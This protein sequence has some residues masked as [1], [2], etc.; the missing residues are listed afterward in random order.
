[1]DNGKRFEMVAAEVV[2]VMV[3]VYDIV[4]NCY[5]FDCTEQSW[6]YCGYSIALAIFDGGMLY[7]QYQTAHVNT[8]RG[9]NSI[10]KAFDKQA[11]DR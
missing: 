10:G 11:K 2:G 8:K 4:T 3:H 1:M 5:T 7:R 6:L 9:E